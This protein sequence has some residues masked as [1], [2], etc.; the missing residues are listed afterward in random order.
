MPKKPKR[1]PKTLIKRTPVGIGQPPKGKG[2]KKSMKLGDPI[3][4]YRAMLASPDKVKDDETGRMKMRESIVQ[5]LTLADDDSLSHVKMRISSQCVTLDKILGGGWATGRVTEIYGPNYVGKSTL[6][7]HAFAEVQKLGGIAVLGD[8]EVSRD[9]RYSAAIGVDITK[10]QYL[11][12]DRNKLSMENMI[13]TIV[14]SINFFAENYPDT[15]VVI[16]WDS[17]GGTSTEEELEKGVGDATVASAAKVLRRA[18]RRI[19]TP[20]GNTK[21]AVIFLNHEYEKINS[22]GRGTGPKRETYGGE[23]IRLCASVRLQ[24]WTDAGLKITDGSFIGREVGAKLVKNRL[25]SPGETRFAM[26]HGVG[27][28]NVWAI[29]DGLVRVGIIAVSG[30]WAA[31]NIEGEVIK[32][33]G[34]LGLGAKCKERPDLFQKLVA[35]YFA[36][37]NV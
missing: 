37:P 10:L 30:S 16:G 11:D 19:T 27:I 34:W 23:A 36:Q 1:S 24:L 7:D 6:L 31:I 28:D 29:Y 18:G 13:T 14:K 12:F 15:P 17:I 5:A 9:R 35:I 4:A 8:A 20:L 32:F 21:I 3:A 33:Q 25:G 2:E 22:M 26:V